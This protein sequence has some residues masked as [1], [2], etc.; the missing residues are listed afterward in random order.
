MAYFQILFFLVGVKI[1]IGVPSPVHSCYQDQL[2]DDVPALN[3]SASIA[4]ESGV[5]GGS[6]TL[7]RGRGDHPAEFSHYQTNPLAPGGIDGQVIPFGEGQQSKRVH[8]EQSIPTGDQGQDYWFN[9]STVQTNAVQWN[10]AQVPGEHNFYIKPKD[11]P[12][13]P[14]PGNTEFSSFASF[15][16]IPKSFLTVEDEKAMT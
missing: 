11:I 14:Y 13:Y 15:P 5:N 6:G 10:C 8:L 12:D 4:D 7:K 16:S 1:T 9:P 2:R 3:P